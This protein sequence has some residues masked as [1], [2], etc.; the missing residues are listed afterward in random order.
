[1]KDFELTLGRITGMDPAEPHFAKAQPPVR[2]DRSAA[3]YVDVIHTDASAFIRGGL[4]IVDPIGHVDYFPNGGT[5]QPGC[6]RSVVE[7][8]TSE[9]GSFIK[10][11]Y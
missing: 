10:G 5:N 2:L 3:H 8:I 9:Q 11:N 1:M 6:G 7:Y 4:G